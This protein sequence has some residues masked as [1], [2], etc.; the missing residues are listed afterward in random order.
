M[1]RAFTVTGSRS[2]V[3]FKK[4]FLQA[5]DDFFAALNALALEESYKIE[6]DRKRNSFSRV[7]RRE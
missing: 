3:F 2:M 7:K 6:C 1:R 4:Q 5:Q